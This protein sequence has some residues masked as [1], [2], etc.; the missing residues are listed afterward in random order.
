MKT[1]LGVQERPVRMLAPRSCAHGSAHVW[2]GIGSCRG[3]GAYVDR[4]NE[5]FIAHQHIGHSEAE[6]NGQDPGSHE[7]LDRFFGGELDELGPAESNT[8]DVGKNVV[9]DDE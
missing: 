4:A 9:G 8:T 5:I 1:G 2:G 3:D 7:A 6:E